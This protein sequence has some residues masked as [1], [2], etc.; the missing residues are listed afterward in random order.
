VPDYSPAD[1]RRLAEPYFWPRLWFSS[2]DRGRHWLKRYDG[3]TQ[4]QCRDAMLIP[5]W[6]MGGG[7][8][9]WDSSEDT[10]GPWE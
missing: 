4:Q 9:N 7:A 10:M 3:P 2:A 5:W 1:F 6:D 8:Q